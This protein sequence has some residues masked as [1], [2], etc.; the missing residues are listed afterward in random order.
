MGELES[1]KDRLTAIR[2]EAKQVIRSLQ[3]HE[4]I[5]TLAESIVRDRSTRSYN[6]ENQSTRICKEILKH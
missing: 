3:Q 5:V 4:G 2:K 6:V 1:L